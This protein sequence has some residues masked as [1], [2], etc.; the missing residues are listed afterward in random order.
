VDFVLQARPH[1]RVLHC[2]RRAAP[3]GFSLATLSA[4]TRRAPRR[5]LG[6]IAQAEDASTDTKMRT[7]HPDLDNA[8]V[9]TEVAC[10]HAET[11]AAVPNPI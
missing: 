9:Q 2:E 4:R 1:P 8:R 6:A 10:I 5:I 7:L 11:D 3:A